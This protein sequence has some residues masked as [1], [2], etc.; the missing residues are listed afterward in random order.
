MG[1]RVEL[2]AFSRT[3]LSLGF[4]YVIGMSKFELAFLG[5]WRGKFKGSEVCALGFS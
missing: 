2:K 3:T 5:Y 4:P 1:F